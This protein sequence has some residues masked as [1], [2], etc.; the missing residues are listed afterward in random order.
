MSSSE[1]PFSDVIITVEHNGSNPFVMISRKMPEDRNLSLAAKGLLTFL[2]TKAFFNK[3]SGREFNISCR[4]LAELLPES[5]DTISRVLRELIDKGY[6]IKARHRN[7]NER[8]VF[9]QYR[10]FETIHAREAWDKKMSKR[11]RDEYGSDEESS[12]AVSE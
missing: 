1:K 6:V 12:T 2:L 9:W 5:K 4:G 10:I 11:M 7:N 3:K 8:W